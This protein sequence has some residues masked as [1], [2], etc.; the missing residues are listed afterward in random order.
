MELYEYLIGGK[1]TGRIEDLKDAMPESKPFR[2]LKEGE[3]FFVSHFKLDGTCF[4]VD[5]IK[6]TSIRKKPTHWAFTGFTKKGIK[7][8]HSVLTEDLDKKLAAWDHRTY[9]KVFSTFKMD[10]DSLFELAKKE[11]K[12]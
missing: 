9:Y 4:Y 6:I 12:N 1:K 5:E 8:V 11:I 2:E 3:S 7:Y 10:A